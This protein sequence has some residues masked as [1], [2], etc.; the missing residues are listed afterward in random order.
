MD[1]ETK[2]NNAECKVR[3]ALVAS[4]LVGLIVLSFMSV[5]GASTF[6]RW[7][8][9][10]PTQYA[11]DVTGT[12]RGIYIRNGESG[13]IGA[14][15]AWAVGGDFLGPTPGPVISHYDGFSWQIV[16]SPLP[17]SPPVIYT[18]VNFC[19]APG[20]PSVG[21]CSA[22]GDGS[23]GWI[24]GG[25]S[26]PAAVALYW[27][28]AALTPV[29]LGL[30]GAGSLNSVF[31]VCHSPQFSSGC[32]TGISFPSGLVYAVGA[33]PTNTH[34]LIYAFNGN[35]KAAGGWTLQFTSA[36]TNGFN[37]VYMY[38]DQTNALAGFAVGK[39]GVVARLNGGS[40]TESQIALG[41]DFQSIFVDQ[42]NPA[43]AWAIGHGGQIWHFA[44]G[45]WTG[46]VNPGVVGTQTL[47]SIF[48]VST[49][50]G[51]IVG[52]AGTIL[53]STNLGSGNVWTALTSPIQTAVG[54]GVD[55]FAVDFTGGGNGW[56]AG[57]NGVILQTSNSGCGSSVPS[58]CWGGST[59]ISQSPHLNAVFELSP[60][61]AW[62]AGM[63]DA[64]SSTTSLMHWD[65]T[66]WHRTTVSPHFV[67]QPD[68]WG[69]F[70][71]SS[72][73]GWAVG[74][75]A[76]QSEALKWDGNSW[77]GQQ[78]SACACEM[79]SVFMT[80]GGLTGDGWAVATGGNIFRYQSGSWGLISSPTT[81]DL[82]S[83]FISNP[84]NNL[85][86][87]WAVGDGGTVL[88]LQIVSGFPTW[89]T[90]GPILG[91]TSDLFTIFFTDANH[92]WIVGSSA[93]VLTTNDGGNSW[94]GGQN[95]VAGAPAN[96]VLRSIFIDTVG[97]GAGNGDG[98][99]VGY[100]GS[101]N[102]VLA[103]WDGQTWIAAPLAPS[104]VAGSTTFGLGL[105]SVSLTSPTDGFAVG[106]GITGATTPLSGIFHLDPPNPPV[107][108][109]TTMETSTSMPTTSESTTSS[110][111]RT[112]ANTIT[113][114]STSIS[115]SI[116]EVSSV[117]TTTQQ[118]T[119]SSSQYTV[120]TPQ[121]LPAI[122][123]FP[124]ESIIVGLAVGLAAVAI[125]RRRTQ[126]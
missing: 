9:I 104:L 35:P 108:V 41:V 83:V 27:D 61:D 95:Q 46:P 23:D 15:D 51:W 99:A 73:E 120:Q 82:H 5:S 12:I 37:G 110:T 40:W 92:G 25:T 113:T 47:Q 6:G 93:T 42:A 109:T 4:F 48:L 70:M 121:T 105:Y 88:K 114:T 115:T 66:K 24:V 19:T 118:I 36:L 84:G 68:I 52:T 32:P 80:S 123:G 49:S 119:V 1:I 22:N 106:A 102:A 29:T 97:I 79:R 111:A 55:L 7:R 87:G 117:T 8:A 31:I 63:F 116:S 57:S 122:P 21:L 81:V 11:S 54:S 16:P 30:G 10:N 74:G 44:N 126:A 17:T 96:T 56:A 13:G 75:S 103:H 18:S 107:A 101:N 26:T 77:V 53:H 45:F 64:A 65:G 125:A 60:S 85:N 91:V 94:S 62:A 124:W 2:L 33:D 78:I 3:A 20:A 50:E 71:L 28:G 43:D 72:S 34:G 76:S 14:G 100:D 59:S 39:N 86:A 67:N 112:S 90:V 69:L 89:V 98:W 38:V 58:P